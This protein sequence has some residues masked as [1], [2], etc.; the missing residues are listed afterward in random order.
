M[1]FDKNGFKSHLAI[2]VELVR[3]LRHHWPLEECVPRSALEWC[4]NRVTGS[5]K[6]LSILSDLF[7]LQVCNIVN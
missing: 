3:E 1:G 4:E 5:C 6:I 7:K 2:K